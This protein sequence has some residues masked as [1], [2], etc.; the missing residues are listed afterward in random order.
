MKTFTHIFLLFIATYSSFGSTL[1]GQSAYKSTGI[2]LRGSYWHTGKQSSFVSVSNSWNNE[3]IDIGHGGAWLCILSRISN[4]SYLEFAI[5]AIGQIKVESENFYRE[6]VDIDGV[7]PILLGIRRHFK[8]FNS[9]STFQPYLS[10]GAGPYWLYE[11]TVTEDLID[12]EVSIKSEIQPGIFV[13]A[14]YDIMFS[15][16]FGINLDMKYHFINFDPDNEH[17]GFELGLGL[18]FFWG[19]YNKNAN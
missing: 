19:S 4:N 8:L 3:S 11:T 5:G 17:N 1:L 7:T 12:T 10:C 15:D 14:G 2:V 18:C 6:E 9:K 13:G 16:W